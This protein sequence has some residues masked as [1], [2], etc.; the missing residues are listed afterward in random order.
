MSFAHLKKKSTQ[1]D[2]VDQIIQKFAQ[3]GNT[4]FPNRATTPTTLPIVTTPAEP[5]STCTLF[6]SGF[7]Y[8]CLRF[9]IDRVGTSQEMR[10]CRRDEPDGIIFKRISKNV[11]VRQCPGKEEDIEF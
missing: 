10:W 4:D 9:S 3:V 5:K 11:L 6:E 1:T 7:C 8:G 2:N